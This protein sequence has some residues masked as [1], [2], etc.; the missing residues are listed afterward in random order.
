[1]NRKSQP[2]IKPLGD[3]TNRGIFYRDWT[4][5]YKDKTGKIW[6]TRIPKGFLTDGSSLPFGLIYGKFDMRTWRSYGPHDWIYFSGC[7][8]QK[9]ADEAYKHELIKGGVKKWKACSAHRTLRIVGRFPYK[10]HRKA[11]KK[12]FKKHAK[13]YGLDGRD[14]FIKEMTKKADKIR[15]EGVKNDINNN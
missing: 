11:E 7:W 14:S 6:R 13:K 10:N 1:M 3:G 2:P 15:K 12:D 9:I 4:Y 8:P 5:F